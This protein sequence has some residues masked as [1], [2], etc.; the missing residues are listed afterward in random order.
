MSRF[1]R[2]KKRTNLYY[3]KACLK[4]LSTNSTVQDLS[5]ELEADETHLGNTED[6]TVLITHNLDKRND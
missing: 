5:T 4:H 2:K 6:T 1:G 3:V